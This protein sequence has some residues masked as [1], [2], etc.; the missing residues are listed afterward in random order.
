MMITQVNDL[1]YAV[2]AG[3]QF[4][5]RQGYICAR[6]FNESAS[7]PTDAQKLYLQ[8]KTS[9][10][11]CTVFLESDK[12]AFEAQGYTVAFKGGSEVIG[13]AYGT[14]N[15]D[16]AQGD[17]L[18]DAVELVAG[19]NPN[20]VDSDN[21]GI[22]D[23]LEYPLAGISTSDPCSPGAGFCTLGVDLIYTNGFE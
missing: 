22:R 23:D 9:D 12:A 17:L 21:D 19:T 1:N 15:S 18:P 3:L 2:N 13:Y 10:D 8:C 16:A 20:S 11:D 7:I 6:C 4:L 14:G 5:G